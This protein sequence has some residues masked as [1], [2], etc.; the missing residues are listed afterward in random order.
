MQFRRSKAASSPRR[1]GFSLIELT[2]GTGILALLAGTLMTA[3]QSLRDVTMTGDMR[4]QMQV[5]G[6]R[7]LSWIVSDLRRSGFVDDAG[8]DF[9]Y[10]FRDGVGVGNF[11][12]H[13]H[14]VPPKQAKPSDSD[15]GFNREVVFLLPADADGDNV[16]DI[17]LNGEL[18][19]DPTHISYVVMMNNA[20]ENVLQRREDAGVPREIARGVERIL[21]EDAA[22]TGFTIP[23]DVLRVRI[24]FRRTDADGDVHRHEVQA[25]VRLRNG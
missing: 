13:S 3:M 22:S 10:L 17:D 7:A 14:T 25:T 21:F 18:V 16:P 15:F 11:V 9:P 19:W 8:D 5:E 4:A 23:L 1:A 2:V 6:E 24:W 12:G 20:G